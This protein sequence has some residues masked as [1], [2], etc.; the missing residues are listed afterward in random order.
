MPVIYIKI[1]TSV[2]KVIRKKNG[3]THT[4][5]LLRLMIPRLILW[6]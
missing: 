1:N 2:P 4:V 6:T 3:I 5:V